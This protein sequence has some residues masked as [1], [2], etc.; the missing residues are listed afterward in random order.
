MPF[1]ESRQRKLR[2]TYLALNFD[3]FLPHRRHGNGRVTRRTAAAAE[4]VVVSGVAAEPP[5]SSRGTDGG[6]LE[7]VARRRADGRHPGESGP[8]DE[9]RVLRDGATEVPVVHLR[10]CACAE[11]KTSHSPT[12]HVMITCNLPQNV[13]FSDVSP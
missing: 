11:T 9:T 4:H 8:A 13:R 12:N 1:C 2:E 5:S 10:C 7:R 6:G 3:D